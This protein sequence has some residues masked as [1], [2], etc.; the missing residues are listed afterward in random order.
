MPQGPFF[1]LEL[2]YFLR[3]PA[4]LGLTIVK[5]VD[6]NFF[7]LPRFGPQRLAKPPLVVGNHACGGVQDIVGRAVILFEADYFCAGEILFKPQNI[8]DLR[9]APAVD[10]LVVVAD[11][12]YIAR[13]L[14]Q[15]PEPLILRNVGVLIFIDKDIFETAVVISQNLRVLRVFQNRNHVQQQIPEVAG[16]HALEPFLITA[17]EQKQFTLGHFP[18]IVHRDLCG[19][20]AA[21]F[22]AI[23]IMDDRF[24]R[25]F[26]GVDIFAFHDLLQK[27]QLI[28]GIENREIARKPDKPRM[29]AQHPRRQ[30]VKRA[31][32]PAFH[33][34][35][36]EKPA[37]AVLHFLCRLV[38]EGDGKNLRR[39][40]LAAMKKMREPRRQNPRLARPCARQHQHGA[41]QRLDRFALRR[42]QVFKIFGF[43][44]TS[45]QCVFLH[46]LLIGGLAMG[47]N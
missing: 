12:A 35:A 30:R 11:A 4:R 8:S 22:P 24:G 5:R 10:R 21:I 27:A 42:V 29:Y 41:V 13:P 31:E 28:V 16:I 36:T 18:G 1:A 45:R 7:A 26:F 15:Q 32:P 6:G 40:C 43:Y 34:L 47:H 9:A 39:V 25:P 17:V 20:Q 33:R 46:G 3:H 14:R 23:N 37:D 38:G 44:G 19:C 2:F